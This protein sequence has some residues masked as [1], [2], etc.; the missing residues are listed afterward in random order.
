MHAHGINIFHGAYR[1]GVAQ[2]VPH[3]FKL[4]LLPARY[5]LFH[6]YL[7]DGRKIQA[8]FGD[9]R[10][11]LR[12]CGNAAARA[13]Q[14]KGRAHDDGIADPAGDRQGGFHILGDIG[15]HAG[16]AN[17][18]HGVPEQLPV[19]GLVNAPDIG[20]QQPHAILV[21]HAGALKLHGQRQ[22]GLAAQPGQQAVGPLLFNDSRHGLDGQRL[23]VNF[24]GQVLIGHDGGRVAVYQHDVQPF[25]LEHPACLGAGIVK[26]C[27]LADNDGPAA[28]HQHFADLLIFWHGFAFLSLGCAAMSGCPRAKSPGVLTPA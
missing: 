20:A 1:Y 10:Q 21:Q 26:L 9:Q 6:Q 15:G 3:G 14:R 13:A 28:D 25:V 16:L 12:R 18:R 22:A 2:A 24:I 5:A 19:L 17:G 23:Q 4:N 8:G 11:F 27:G 7:G